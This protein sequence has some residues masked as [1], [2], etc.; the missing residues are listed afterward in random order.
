MRTSTFEIINACQRPAA[1]SCRSRPS[2]RAGTLTVQ[3][4]LTKLYGFSTDWEIG[5]SFV[6]SSA[7][8]CIRL[9]RSNVAQCPSGN[10]PTR[11]LSEVVQSKTRLGSKPLP[12]SQTANPTVAT[13]A[14]RRSRHARTQVETV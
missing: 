2:R 8:F 11:R 4:D 14:P 13:S 1:S 6:V 12:I 9:A 7:L 10:D 5:D 3:L